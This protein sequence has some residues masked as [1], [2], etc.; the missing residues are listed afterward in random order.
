MRP[1]E[2]EAVIRSD[3]WKRQLYAESWTTADSYNMSIGQGYV[4]ATPLQVLVST[5]AVANGGEGVDTGVGLL[6]AFCLQRLK[7]LIVWLA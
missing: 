6:M 5:A 3:Q 4:L 1:D 2:V 7:E